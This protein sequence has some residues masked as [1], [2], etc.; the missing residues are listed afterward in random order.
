MNIFL[1]EQNR[2]VQVE[3]YAIEEKLSVVHTIGIRSFVLENRADGGLFV[4]LFLEEQRPLTE[5][6]V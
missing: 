6:E 1:A 5:G 3:V 4:E 2:R